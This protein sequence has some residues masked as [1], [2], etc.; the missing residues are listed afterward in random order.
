VIVAIFFE[1]AMD[2]LD[3][4]ILGGS[5]RHSADYFVIHSTAAGEV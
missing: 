5:C 2:L 4:D 3:E 1:T